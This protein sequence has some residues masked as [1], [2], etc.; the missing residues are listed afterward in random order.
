MFEPDF[1]LSRRSVNLFISLLIQKLFSAWVK[2]QNLYWDGTRESLTA[3]GYE[4]YRLWMHTPLDI[5][6]TAVLVIVAVVA[7]LKIIKSYY[8]SYSH[9]EKND[10][11]VSI[12]KL[13]FIFASF[14]IAI[15]LADFLFFDFAFNPIYTYPV[16]IGLGLLTYGLAF[17]GIL[18][19]DF[20]YSFE[21]KSDSNEF[22]PT[23][24]KIAL[25]M[26][27]EKFYLDPELNTNK[28]SELTGIK[29]YLLS[30][31]INSSEEKGVTH[32]INKHRVDEF[33]NRVVDPQYDH[34][35]ILS[36]ALDS[37][38][39]SKASANR[40]IKNITG[41]SPKELKKSLSSAN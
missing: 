35:T 22:K 31:A 24:D 36:I 39:N 20:R 5:V 19:K 34:H 26:K 3:L 6:M 4:S 12:L 33:K 14:A 27:Q 30:K 2:I 15:S 17:F 28:L 13:Y 11:L 29:S 10:H 9:R 8:E 16:F 1:R 21:E 40:I 25:M 41:K 37:G 38:F 32:F 18:R 23:Y 7:G